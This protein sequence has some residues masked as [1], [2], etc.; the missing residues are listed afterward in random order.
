[1]SE[2]K[3]NE[4]IGDLYALR[5]GLSL[6]AQISEN[7]IV[8][9]K[10]FNESLSGFVSETRLSADE[11]TQYIQAPKYSNADEFCYEKNDSLAQVEWFGSDEFLEKAN[12]WHN[13]CEK[14]LIRECE[15]EIT[16]NKTKKILDL[17]AMI[18]CIP[19]VLLCV[20]LIP[21]LMIG[22]YLLLHL[23]PFIK[24]EIYD[25][26]DCAKYDQKENQRILDYLRTKTNS[27]DFEYYCGKFEY[28][29]SKEVLKSSSFSLYAHAKYLL[30]ISPSLNK[31]SKLIIEKRKKIYEEKLFPIKEI[32]EKLYSALQFGYSSMLS[33]SD[34]SN[35]DLII[36]YLETNR[37]DTIKEALQLLDEEIR[38]QRIE[39]S[40]SRASDGIRQMLGVGFASLQK[41]L[42]V[43]YEGLSNKLNNISIGIT[44]ENTISAQ[45]VSSVELNNALQAKANENSAKLLQ[46]AKRL[47]S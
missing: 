42:S 22:I 41:S 2:N 46:E 10:G 20:A 40:I 36:Y 15:R 32:G 16:K 31:K 4:I 39:Q 37:A 38:T 45:L 5:A 29:S 11:L 23:I 21:F 43:S 24:D 9:E 7:I 25:S 18:F 12:I 13:E 47:K 33:E 28:F 8:K 27:R 17:I 26:Y 1:M 35:L 3:K 14:D 44:A 30:D 19:L 34:W 6:A